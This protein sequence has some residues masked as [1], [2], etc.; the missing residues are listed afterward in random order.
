ML[1]VHWGADRLDM[2]NRIA[3]KEAGICIDVRKASADI[4]KTSTLQLLEN[5]NYQ[6][7]ARVI[8]EAYS[9][10]DGAKTAAGLIERV[11]DTGKPILRKKGSSITLES[12]KDLPFCTEP[13]KS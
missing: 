7:G 2:G 5:P 13:A 3:R 1:V 6:K 9:R 12:I 8:K 4:I 10:C 11:A